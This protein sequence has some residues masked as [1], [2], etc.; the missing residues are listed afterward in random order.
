M[1]TA[2]SQRLSLAE[3]VVAAIAGRD[4]EQLPFDLA[5]VST[6]EMVDVL[7]RLVREVS[8][9]R[10]SLKLIDTMVHCFDDDRF[11]AG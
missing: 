3:Q 2:T 8:C 10:A 5:G 1:S 7:E 6:D 11:G 4:D 9:H